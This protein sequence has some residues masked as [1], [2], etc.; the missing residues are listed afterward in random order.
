MKTIVERT[1]CAS[2]I[3]AAADLEGILITFLV[4][5]VVLVVIG[6]LLYGI[7]Q[8]IIKGP[9]PAP[10]RLVIGLVLI[11][12]VIIWGLRLFGGMR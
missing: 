5:V 10:V 11:V 8:W 12:L 3:I 9:L 4:L 2:S 6:A 7:E 1:L